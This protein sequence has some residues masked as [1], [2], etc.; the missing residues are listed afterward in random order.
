[1]VLFSTIFVNHGFNDAFNTIRSYHNGCFLGK[2]NQCI[3][4]IKVP[5]CE[6]T[7]ICKKL[8]SYPHQVQGLNHQ[9]HG[10]I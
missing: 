8:P 3:Q 5:Y 6:Q 10:W 7:T 4:L 2:G 1:M 9:P